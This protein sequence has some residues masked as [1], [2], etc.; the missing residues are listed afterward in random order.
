[1]F[2]AI[3][4]KLDI[5][6]VV[7]LPPNG[8]EI[9]SEQITSMF[10]SILWFPLH[11]CRKKWR[12]EIKMVIRTWVMISDPRLRVTEVCPWKESSVTLIMCLKTSLGTLAGPCIWL[13]RNLGLLATTAFGWWVLCTPKESLNV[14]KNVQ[15]KVLS[16]TNRILMKANIWPLPWCPTFGGCAIRSH[17]ALV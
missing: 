11:L 8:P 16:N 3:E 5:K 10:Y 6:P 17:T 1:M 9:I 12:R 7:P 14:V 4:H 2:V 15:V 13:I